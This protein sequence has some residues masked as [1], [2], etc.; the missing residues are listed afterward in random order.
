MECSEG[1]KHVHGQPE[2]ATESGHLWVR[3]RVVDTIE[4]ISSARF[5]RYWGADDE[6]LFGL[7]N[8]I[9]TDLP[10]LEHWSLSDMVHV[11]QVTSWDG[12]EPDESAEEDLQMK[13]FVARDAMVELAGVNDRL[14]LCMAMS[15]R[16]GRRF[17]KT[18]M[19]RIGL[20]PAAGSRPRDGDK[21][22][23]L[24]VIFHGFIV[25]IIFEP[26]DDE[27][28]EYKVVGDCYI[29]GIMHGDA[30]T[31]EEKDTQTFVLVCDGSLG[32]FA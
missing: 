23:S 11:L 4:A 25:P 21:K 19:G 10:G 3:G 17:M 6:Y 7:L 12:K 28:K 15:T 18:E 20:A 5:H 26:V 30:I 27:Q 1:T 14:G 22:G 31:W 2:D 16:R 32:R 29:E 8:Q 9:K 13:E 24:I